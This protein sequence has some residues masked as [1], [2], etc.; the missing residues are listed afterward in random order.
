MRIVAKSACSVSPSRIGEIAT[1]AR[2]Y[3]QG[4]FSIDGVA[5]GGMNIPFRVM[6]TKRTGE[7]EFG[8]LWT[9]VDGWTNHDGG[10]SHFGPFSEDDLPQELKG[11]LDP[12]AVFALTDDN[13]G[14]ELTIDVT[15]AGY[16]ITSKRHIGRSEVKSESAARLSKLSDKLAEA[17]KKRAEVDAKKAA[18]NGKAVQDILQGKTPEQ[19]REEARQK[20]M[21]N[22]G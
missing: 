21:A 20:R 4:Q 6:S 12:D 1:L 17:A 22:R 18:Q 10:K 13:E 19:S 3:I 15:D 16:E 11:L 14:F 2:G 9:A 5:V 8:A 7:A